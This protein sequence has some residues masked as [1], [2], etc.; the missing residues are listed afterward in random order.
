VVAQG[1]SVTVLVSFAEAVLTPPT[2]A[3]AGGATLAPTAMTP[4]S[5][6]TFSYVYTTGA[7]E[8]GAVTS[9]VASA[10]SVASGEMMIPAQCGFTIMLPVLE[11]WVPY[12][13]SGIRMTSWAPPTIGI[14]WDDAAKP[15]FAPVEK[16]K[17]EHS[18]SLSP[19]AWQAI[20][21]VNRT[22][23]FGETSYSVYPLTDAFLDPTQNFFRLYRRE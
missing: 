8:L 15:Q 12:P 6:T 14:F 1:Q 7:P 9:T 5:P 2:L 13:I 16:Y 10:V 20:I 22:R 17:L 19:T 23:P 11:N 21:E 4:L 3:L 18:P